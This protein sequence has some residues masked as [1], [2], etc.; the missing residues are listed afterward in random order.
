MT[1][2]TRKITLGETPLY[3]QDIINNFKEFKIEP[4]KE[5]LF[6]QFQNITVS[7]LV[8]VKK[9]EFLKPK[10]AIN[11]TPKKVPSFVETINDFTHIKGKEKIKSLMSSLNDERIYIRE[12]GCFGSVVMSGKQWK[13]YLKNLIVE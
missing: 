5:N 9:I 8:S 10:T 2:K 7:N 3:L 13:S 6:L 1:N 4:S 11:F 12:M